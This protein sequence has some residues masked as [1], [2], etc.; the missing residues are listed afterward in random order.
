MPDILLPELVLISYT[1]FVCPATRV[2]MLLLLHTSILP[3][4]I[5]IIYLWNDGS[6]I[7]PTANYLISRLVTCNIL[8]TSFR[9][10]ATVLNKGQWK[11]I[12]IPAKAKCPAVVVKPTDWLLFVITNHI[13]H[14]VDCWDCHVMARSGLS[15]CG[16]E[17]WE[18][19]C[20]IVSYKWML[21]DFLDRSLLGALS[22]SLWAAMRKFLML[23]S[24][25]NGKQIK[26][27]VHCR[28]T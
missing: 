2:F 3:L 5:T 28:S 7:K 24:D 19:S 4:S 6:K 1:L 8:R 23:I 15:C 27:C 22:N 18:R 9:E 21:I 12:V 14:I 17:C 20:Y 16:T 10:G 13:T 25:T 26:L 11:Q